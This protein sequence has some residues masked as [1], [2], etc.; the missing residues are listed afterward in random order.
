MEESLYADTAPS[1][2]S[3]LNRSY[4]CSLCG[5]QG[6]N[7]ERCPTPSI[8]YQLRRDPKLVTELAKGAPVATSGTVVMDVDEFQPTDAEFTDAELHTLHDLDFSKRAADGE[9]IGL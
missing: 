4:K 5:Q 2:S 6:H 8:D 7:R 1:I 3:N 9:E